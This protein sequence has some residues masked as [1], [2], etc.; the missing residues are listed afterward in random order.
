MSE[1]N[2]KNEDAAAKTAANDELGVKNDTKK[3]AVKK[4]TKAASK[5]KTTV[6]KAAKKKA[7]KKTVKKVAQKT[8]QASKKAQTE[9]IKTMEKMMTKGQAQFDQMA[10]DAANNSKENMDAVVKSSNI[11]MKG[12]EDLTKTYV[13]WAQT[14]AEKNA[15][16]FKTLMGAKTLN[17]F[18]D[19]QNKIAQ[20]NFD[21]FMTGAT[22]IS[23]LSVKVATEAFEPINDQM[24]KSIKSATDTMA[25]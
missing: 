3:T 16:A 4:T 22:K 2:K 21:D 25:A 17:E 14:S 1:E 19:T 7:P 13:S 11:F 8:V 9:N 15:K 5:K 10:K 6:K 12:F 24:A 20:Q 23:E 18:T